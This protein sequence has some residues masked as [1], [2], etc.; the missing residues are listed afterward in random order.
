[1]KEARR[2]RARAVLDREERLGRAS[3]AEAAHHVEVTL[4]ARGM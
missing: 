2:Q 3:V 4:P 1:M